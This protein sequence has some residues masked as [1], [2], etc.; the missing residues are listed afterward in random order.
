MR[1][2]G[3]ES[4]VVN[5]AEPTP[6][7]VVLGFLTIVH[8]GV[9]WVGGYLITNGWGRPLEFRLT[10]PVQPNRVQAALYGPTLSEYLFADLIGKTLIE[11]T[12]IRPDIV[13]TDVPEVMSLAGRVGMPVVAIA[14]ENVSGTTRTGTLSHPRSP[15]PLVLPSVGDLSA[16]GVIRLLDRVDPSVDLT[17]PFG[18]IREAL[19]EHRKFGT[20]HRAA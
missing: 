8:E 9:G 15:R 1:E 12:A 2:S 5:S 10:T 3:R 6:V 4:Y 17:E 11:K 7:P 16:E 19:A 18:R 13:I 14:A 20:T